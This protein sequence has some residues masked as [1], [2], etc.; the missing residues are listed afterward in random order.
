M[1]IM[2]TNPSIWSF[3][4]WKDV[5]ERAVAT[6]AQAVVLK[7]GS[8]SV[9][10]NALTLNWPELGGFALG[11]ALLAVLKA[12]VVNAATKRGAS[13]IAKSDGEV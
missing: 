2:L 10:V 1:M 5:A 4:Y 3:D 9:A 6:A 13:P 11:G 12:L 8:D 7:I